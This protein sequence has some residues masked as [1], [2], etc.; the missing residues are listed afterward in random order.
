VQFGDTVQGNSQTALVARMFNNYFSGINDREY[1]RSVNVFAPSSP[2]VNPNSPLSE[3][4]FA[5]AD[6]TSQDTDVTLTNLDPAGGSL[7]TSAE[8]TFQSTQAAGL[9]PRDAPYET[10]TQWDIT[11]QL[12]TSPSGQ[13]Q[14]YDTTS[15][16]DSPC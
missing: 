14:I 2:I 10:C 4:A 3:P 13:Y 15:D 6:R 9:G 5:K 12:T 1:Q 11:F 8:V 7:V 16:V